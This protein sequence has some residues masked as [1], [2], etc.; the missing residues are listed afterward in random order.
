MCLASSKDI[1]SLLVYRDLEG[2]QISTVEIGAFATLATLRILSVK[3]RQSS[4]R[5]AGRI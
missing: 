4:Y 3:P 1:E 2:N 5:W